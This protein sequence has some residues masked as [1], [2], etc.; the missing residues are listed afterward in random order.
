MGGR[1]RLARTRENSYSPIPYPA[2]RRRSEPPMEQQSEW[3]WNIR[4]RAEPGEPL[5]KHREGAGSAGALAGLEMV[6]SF[7]PPPAFRH[8]SRPKIKKPTRRVGIARLR[9]CAAVP[10]YK[11]TSRNVDISLALFPSPSNALGLSDAR[12]RDAAPWPLYEKAKED[13]TPPH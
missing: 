3:T 4:S 10:D 13:A 9:H 12:C 8:C 11:V 6:S 7:V 2:Q 1:I 5:H